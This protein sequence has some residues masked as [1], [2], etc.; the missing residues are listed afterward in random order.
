[1]KRKNKS[2]YKAPIKK[3]PDYGKII[4][5][6]VLILGILVALLSLA[7][8]S[9]SA[10]LVIQ[11]DSVYVSY[12]NVYA[13]TMS[14]AD[15]VVIRFVQGTDTTNYKMTEALTGFYERKMKIDSSG[16]LIA[17]VDV[18]GF[19]P[20]D[21]TKRIYL[22]AGYYS[23]AINDFRGTGT[24]D[25]GAQTVT[26]VFYDTVNSEVVP[27]L[28]HGVQN[29]SQTVDYDYKWSL[30]SGIQLWSLDVGSYVVQ[31]SNPNYYASSIP[32]TITV[33][34]TQTDTI[35]VYP[36]ATNWPHKSRVWSTILD[37]DDTGRE[38]VKVTVSTQYSLRYDNSPVY[39]FA[40][41]YYTDSVGY[42][43]FDLIRSDSLSPSNKAYYTFNAIDT[44][45]GEIVFE[46]VVV[47]VPDSSTWELKWWRN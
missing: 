15:S 16:F 47:K 22:S 12:T 44:L 46:N 27:Y 45:T 20:N 36:S 10:S 17:L 8:S 19:N 42:F 32:D 26:F 4:G 18:Y 31:I 37:K 1:M 30:S 38:G 29:V 35:K 7:T 25:S 23:R 28:K 2:K 14:S 33:A 39:Q 24:A 3:E 6:I 11:N 21:T 5:N 34:G 40:E 43:Y 9:N 13:D 41:T